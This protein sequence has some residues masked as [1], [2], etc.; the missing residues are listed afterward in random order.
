M[1]ACK[2]GSH[3]CPIIWQ[4]PY[5]QPVGAEFLLGGLFAKSVLLPTL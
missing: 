1:A 4:M 2:K 3:C 5:Y